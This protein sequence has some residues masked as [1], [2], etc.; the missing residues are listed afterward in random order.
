[1]RDEIEG[2]EGRKKSS[3]WWMDKQRV[4]QREGQGLKHGDRQ[5]RGHQIGQVSVRRA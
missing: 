5:G 4:D 1:M 2:S 3:T